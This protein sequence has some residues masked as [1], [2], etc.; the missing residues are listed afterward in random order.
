MGL[1]KKNI[2]T[3]RIKAKALLQVPL[4][5]DINVSD[6][7][8]DVARIICCSG[9]V[10]TDEIKMGMNKIWVKGR[11]VFQVLYQ[12]DG[13]DAGI[14]GMDGEIPFMEEIYLDKMEGQDRVIC[15]AQLDDLRVQI[16]NSRKLSIQAVIS[17]EPKVEET[18]SEEICTE[19]EGADTSGIESGLEYRK[20]RLDY[21]ETVVKKRD[22]LRIHEEI[23]LPSG[24]PDIGAALW[25]SMDILQ[26][27]FRAADEKLAVSGEM[28]VFVVYREDNSDKINWYEATV[29]FSGN[30][31]CQNSREGMLADVCYDIGH[32]EISIRDDSDGEPRMIG[33][34]AA[35]E[36][37]IKLYER[38]QEQVVADVYGV[39]CE[40]NAVTDNRSFRNLLSEINIEEKLTRAI[41]IE[42]TENKV[43]QV[44]HCDSHA[45]V[46]EVSFDNNEIHITGTIELKLLYTSNAEEGTI[47]PIKESVPFEVTRAFEDAGGMDIEQYTVDVQVTQ[48]TVSIKDSSQ[49][50]WHGVLNIRVLVYDS[51]NEAI[52][53]DLKLSPIPVEVLEGLPGFAIYYV[54]SGDSLWQ[55]GKK[56]YVSVERIKEINNLTDD[57][58]HAGDRLLIVK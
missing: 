32:E 56:Y 2:H 19:I 13:A 26:I 10:K 34:E 12:T 8:P 37:E 47:Y 16:I 21:L 25:K 11:L 4:E 48:Q 22:L 9:R 23:K 5:E 58:I 27:N 24:M 54:K 30:V 6:T 46:E 55:I 33:I 45:V 15:K 44:C 3:E 50:E 39:S 38:E 41:K 31:E 52:L 36:L 1:L 49:L 20:K 42:D 35:L 53:T 43:L 28:S 29:P 57:V 18:V 51:K 14:A 7:K 40:V 17:F